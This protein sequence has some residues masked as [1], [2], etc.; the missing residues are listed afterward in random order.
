MTQV[1]ED[2]NAKPT[3]IRQGPLWEIFFN[4][5]ICKTNENLESELLEEPFVL[6]C[7]VSV[8]ENIHYYQCIS[9][10]RTIHAFY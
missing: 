1:T 9:T 2:K 8:K 10:C 5:F 6:A 7:L 4:R 3:E